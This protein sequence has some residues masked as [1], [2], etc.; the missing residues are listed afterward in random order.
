M[1]IETDEEVQVRPD[2][3]Q[4]YSSGYNPITTF[5]YLNTLRQMDWIFTF[6]LD[7]CGRKGGKSINF[8]LGDIYI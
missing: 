3:K 6:E 5:V 2:L 8:S 7:K 1:D 4:R